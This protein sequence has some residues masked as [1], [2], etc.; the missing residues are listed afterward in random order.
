MRFDRVSAANAS[1]ISF[2]FGPLAS[3][4]LFA[5][6]LFLLV[7]SAA[8]GQ[9]G[10]RYYRV[11]LGDKGTPERVI[12]PSDPLYGA[13]TA[14][15]TERALRRRAKVLPPEGL[16]S[17]ADLPV[18]ADYIAAITNLG[19]EIRQ[20]SRWLNTVM[21]YTDS[22]T[23]ELV[24]A[25][26]FVDSARTVRT[27]R[28]EEGNGMEKRTVIAAGSNGAGNDACITSLYGLSD[29]QNRAVRIDAA[30]VTGFAGEGVL[31]GVLDAGFNW[32]DHQGLKN[33][34][35]IAERDFVNRDDNTA[36]EPGQTPSESHGTLVM[37][38]IGGWLEGTL[39][40]GAPRAEFALAKT[41]DVGSELHIEEDNF[42]AG[43]EWLEALGADIT[44]ASLGYTTFDDPEKEHAYEELDGH[45]AFASRGINA[46]ARLGVLCIA[47]AGNEF[48]SYRYVSVPA[49]ADS[50][51]AVAALDTAGNVAPFS[52]RGFDPA[53]PNGRADRIKPDI[54]A[55]GVRVYGAAAGT[56]DG[57]VAQQGTS[58]ATPIVAAASAIILSARP[59][60]R[61]W[62]VRELFYETSGN[63]GN[64]DTAVGYGIIDVNRALSSLS[65]ERPLAGE[66]KVLSWKGSLSAAAWIVGDGTS[67]ITA[68][69][70][71]A[72]GPRLRLTLRNLRTA[73]TVSE[74]TPQPVNGP[75]QWLIRGGV[76][77]LNLMPGD[78]MEV[79]IAL[80]SNETELR[81]TVLCATDALALPASTLCYDVPLPTT[82]LAVARPNPF[83]EGTRIEF[84]LDRSATV[85]LDVFNVA[86]ERVRRL[87]GGQQI[88][89]GFHSV[90][91]NP[92]DMP[93][94]A[95]YYRLTVD[96]E[97]Y[98]EK[99]IY[100]K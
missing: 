26:P 31:V 30:H 83:H 38:I 51:L 7:S 24:K 25:L 74:E 70:Q 92:A 75:A 14:H 18:N 22:A 91:L 82:S 9:E 79:V 100:L 86:G 43:L 17:T 8:Q 95:Y 55:P 73:A 23:Y 33:V 40:G 57:V 3:R 46:A 65:R 5:F 54:A 94:G 71:S 67:E 44:T 64:P 59:D 37:S 61:P 88:D 1:F 97:V 35:V 63:A 42:V 87:L 49:E 41:E 80:A 52:S 19:G 4:I 56:G 93:G 66:P 32:R 45:T 98:S 53:S 77:E 6:L 34:R 84:A 27:R 21:I 85:S 36:D 81:R 39:I 90:L 62:E 12:P 29:R 76:E 16:V 68:W 96:D 10:Y 20:T 15:L 89:P 2:G 99:M 78:S 60:L 11:W 13:A 47:A 48:T 72:E 50:A 69:K 28:I 58:L